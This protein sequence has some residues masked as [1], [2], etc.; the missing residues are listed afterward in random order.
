MT[1]PMSRLAALSRPRLLVRAARFGMAE[2]NR[3]RSLRRLL[4][5]E[6]TPAPG[7]AFEALLKRESDMDAA[8]RE[9]IAAYSPALHIEMLAALMHE[10]R[11]AGHRMAA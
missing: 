3:S 11:I 4:P 6:A 10:A 2:F 8:R 9:G 5:G 1:D 7:Q